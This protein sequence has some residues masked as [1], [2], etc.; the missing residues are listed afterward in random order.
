MKMFSNCINSSV[1]LL[2]SIFLSPSISISVGLLVSIFL[3]CVRSLDTEFHEH[4]QK[5]KWSHSSRYVPSSL[6]GKV[7]GRLMVSSLLRAGPCAGEHSLGK[8]PCG[9][10]DVKVREF[11][12]APWLRL[13]SHNPSKSSWAGF[14]ENQHIS[15]PWETLA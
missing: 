10:G 3:T 12:L 1:E 14:Y 5:D 2:V 8:D 7:E 6:A 11:A 15:C 4:M 9:R 13:C